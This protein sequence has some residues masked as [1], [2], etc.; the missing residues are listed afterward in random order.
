MTEV[1]AGLAWY[2]RED[3]PKLLAIFD[4]ADSLPDTYEEWLEE[5]G[6]IE[7]KLI[8]Q[9]HRVVRAAIDPATFP[10]W[11]EAKGLKLDAT[12][13]TRFAME[14]AESSWQSREAQ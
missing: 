6:E 12:A 5:A 13:R 14:Q 3:Y 7:R 9:G 1:V 10:G 2:K 8:I 4:D 11:C